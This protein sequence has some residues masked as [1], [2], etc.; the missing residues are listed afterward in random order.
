MSNTLTNI[1]P[2]DAGWV[3]DM[4]PEMAQAA[5]VAHGSFVIFYFKDGTVEAEIL[6]PPSAELRAEVR[7]IA[8]E[9]ADAFAEMKR[10]GD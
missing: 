8:D 3:L 7:D 6:P 5:G 9:F 4:T 1:K 10:R 2:A